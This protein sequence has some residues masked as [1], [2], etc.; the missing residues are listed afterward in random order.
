[1]LLGNSKERSNQEQ[2]VDYCAR[3]KIE[4][5]GSGG[6]YC[7]VGSRVS[8]HQLLKLRLGVWQIGVERTEKLSQVHCR[9]GRGGMQQSGQSSDGSGVG[10]LPSSSPLIWAFL[11]KLLIHSG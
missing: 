9:N 3:I 6:K 4:E 7:L 10:K 5:L 1:M 8:V 11:G 2:G